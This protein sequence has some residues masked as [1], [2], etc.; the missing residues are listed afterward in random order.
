M[1]YVGI[2]VAKAT[3]V[4]CVQPGDRTFTVANTATGHRQLLAVL[5][6]LAITRLVLEATGGYERLVWQRLCRAGLPAVRVQPRRIKALARALGREAKTDALDAA[7][8]AEAARLLELPVTP[9]PTPA[10][11]ALRALVDLRQH[12]VAQRDAHRRRLQQT[13]AQPVRTV[14][15]RLIKSL[16]QELRQLELRIAAQ[17]TRT[18]APDLHTAPGAGPVLCAT[19]AA[20]LP[21]LG[22]LDRRQVA[23]LVGIAPY[24]TD[25]GTQQGR[26][27]IRGGRPELRRVLYMAT[28]TAV[29]CCPV[30]AATYQRLLARGKLKKVALVACMRKFLI[31]LNAMAKHRTTWAPPTLHAVT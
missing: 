26:R 17:L 30:L 7:L 10:T 24:N 12:L 15:S 18:A 3:L 31:M 6:P 11:E 5:K 1:G 23:A 29:R 2:D 21:E 28:L 16:Q 9:V 20:R 8:L 14:L 27:H 13:T 19:L 22:Q 25:S 4:V